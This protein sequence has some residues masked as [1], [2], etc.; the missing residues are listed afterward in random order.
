M[1]FGVSTEFLAYLHMQMNDFRINDEYFGN[2]MTQ[3]T[4][5]F[6]SEIGK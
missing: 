2:E 4:D 1:D 3:F 6:T 5:A